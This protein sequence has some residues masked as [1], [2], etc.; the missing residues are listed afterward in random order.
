MHE[1]LVNARFGCDRGAAGDAFYPREW[2]APMR[3]GILADRRWAV[4]GQRILVIGPGG[5]GKSTFSRALGTATG[6]LVVH[7]DV[8][9]WKPNWVAVSADE[10]RETIARL[11]AGERWIL[12]G[13]YSGSLA[14]RLQRCDTVFFFDFPRWLCFWGVFKRRLSVLAPRRNDLAAGCRER[15]SGVFLRWL[16]RY[17]YISRPRTLA[18]IQ[19]ANPPVRVVVIRNRRDAR[20]ALAEVTAHG[21]RALTEQRL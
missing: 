10:W 11:A 7:L 1:N 16:W 14:L 20:R 5:A 3:P 9:Y 12:D 4:W 21:A 13:N 18:A 15:L 19:Q 6:L 2:G 17:P 8:H